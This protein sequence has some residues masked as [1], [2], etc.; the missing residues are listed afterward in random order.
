[1]TMTKTQMEARIKELEAQ[2]EAKNG[3][4][5]LSFKV[6]QKGA[7]SVYG[8]GR[9][10]TTLYRSQWERLLEHEA[11]LREFMKANAGKLIVKASS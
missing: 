1:M 10:P 9:W 8:L 6:S 3:A 11:E 7:L 4:G 5:T 2:A